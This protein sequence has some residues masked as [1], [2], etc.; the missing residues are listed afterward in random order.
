MCAIMSI[1]LARSSHTDRSTPARARQFWLHG[2]LNGL[3]NGLKT[4]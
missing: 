4:H 3:L 1:T 2:L